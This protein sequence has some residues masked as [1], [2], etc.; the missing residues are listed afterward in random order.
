MLRVR[1]LAATGMEKS[2]VKPGMTGGRAW[3]PGRDGNDRGRTWR[4]GMETGHG[5]RAWRQGTVIRKVLRVRRLVGGRC[6]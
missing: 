3:R 2:S 5:D 6:R 1:V 4:Q